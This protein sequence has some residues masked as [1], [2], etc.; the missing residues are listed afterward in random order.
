[1]SLYYLNVSIHVLA[2][3]LWLGGM[4]FLAAVGAPVLRKVEPAALRAQLFTALGHQFRTVGW[5][6]I[7]VLLVTGVANLHFRGLLRAD[8]WMNPA[9]WGSGYGQAL[10]WKLAAVVIMVSASA[11]HDFVHGPAASRLTPGTPEALAMRRRAA[12]LGRLNAVVGIVLVLAA[13]RLSRGV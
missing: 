4:F 5:I 10:G 6:T 13:V 9:F 1:M 12:W 7:A 3:L 8:L 2:A 11:V